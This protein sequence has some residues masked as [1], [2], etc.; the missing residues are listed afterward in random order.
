[1]LENMDALIEW[2]S[3]ELGIEELSDQNQIAWHLI[4]EMH[5]LI[6]RHHRRSKTIAVFRKLHPE[7]SLTTCYRYYDRTQYVLGSTHRT[8]RNYADLQL[9]EILLKGIDLAIQREDVSAIAKLARELREHRAE[10]AKRIGNKEKYRE[11]TYIVSV[12]PREIGIEP[13]PL[14][15]IQ[16]MLD[17]LDLSKGLTEQLK[18]QAQTVPFTEILP[19]DKD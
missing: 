9:E 18:H 5:G 1:M 19:N 16:A 12:D 17:G 3:S 8:D 10:Q 2:S 11:H 7:L 4:N 6:L 15:K 14:N 13:E